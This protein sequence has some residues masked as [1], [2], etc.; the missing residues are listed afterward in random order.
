MEPF[1]QFQNNSSRDPLLLKGWCLSVQQSK[2]FAVNNQSQRNIQRRP[3]DFSDDTNDRFLV[4]NP[5]HGKDRCR[6]EGTPAAWA[7]VDFPYSLVKAAAE[8]AKLK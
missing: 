6:E 5:S 4:P 3:S 2:N 7:A 8:I 1:E